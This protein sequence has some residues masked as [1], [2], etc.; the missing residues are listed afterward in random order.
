MDI[1]QAIDKLKHDADAVLRREA[2][3]Y[4]VTTGQYSDEAI[5]AF[6]H[7][8]SDKDR[9]VRDICS[10]ALAE[11]DGAAARKAA[12]LTTPFITR[13]DIE[14]RNLAGEILAKLGSEA[15]DA[16]LP[17]LKDKDPDVRKF[18]C[19]V[20]GIIGNPVASD[21]VYPLL[22]DPD[23]N[24][25]SSAIET[26]GNMGDEQALDRLFAEYDKNEDLKPIIIEAVGKIGGDKAEDFLLQLLRE[27]EDVFLQ[28]TVI[29]ALAFTGRDISICRKL[30]SELP[31]TTSELQVILLK[32]I[33]AIAFRLEEHIEL[34]DDLRYIANRA[35]MDEDPDIR[36]AGLVALGPEFREDDIPGLVNEVLLSEP[37]VQQHVLYVLMV[38]SSPEI[39]DKFIGTFCQNSH[40]DDTVIE[41]LSLM[42]GI[43]PDAT[44]EN[45]DRF[46][47]SLIHMLFTYPKGNAAEVLDL[48]I[49][50]EPAPVEREVSF[51][52]QSGSPDQKSEALDAVDQLELKQFLPEVEKIAATDGDLQSRAKT[53]MDKFNVI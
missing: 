48:L 25:V 23:I 27:E 21:N 6:A 47:K 46:L 40:P 30:L 26:L 7:G 31:Y 51:F 19:D 15:I 18:A 37:D 28:T 45:K 36:A 42:S 44:E 22:E 53:L 32:T 20:L 13:Q 24:V 52:L 12:R 50:L 11:A 10:Q 33:Y 39:V 2:A 4:I 49:K 38:H 17:Y 5:E 16:L 8:L 41:F 14:L 1:T 9:G 34:P 3:N 29:D 35:L 43:W